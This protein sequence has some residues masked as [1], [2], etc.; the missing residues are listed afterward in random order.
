M[1]QKIV[2]KKILKVVLTVNLVA[3][4]VVWGLSQYISAFSAT[5]LSDFLFYVLIVIWGVAGLTWEGA[6]ESRNRDIDPAAM[7][8]PLLHLEQ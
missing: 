6:K 1:Q 2:M 5:C 4:I 8:M 7:K 3:A